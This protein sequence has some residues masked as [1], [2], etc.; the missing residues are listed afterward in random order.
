MTETARSR[1]VSRALALSTSREA[2]LAVAVLAVQIVAVLAYIGATGT[3]VLS[4]RETLYPVAWITLSVYFVA[5]VWR[6]GPAVRSS[7]AAVLA[8]L[9]YFLLLAVLA[10]FVWPG[11]QLLGHHASGAELT[12]FWRSPGWGPTVTYSSGVVQGAVV[13]FKL[14]AYSA[15]AY[16]I[17][18]A[19][20]A[21]SRG[22]LA[23]VVGMFSCV[24]CVL[25]VIGAVAGI[26][27]GSGAVASTVNGSYDLGT[28]VFAVTIVMLLV[29]IPTAHPLADQ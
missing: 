14:V 2:L 28:A 21:S 9:G 4:L 1:G 7:T 3:Q 24:G 12:V 13:P 17:A 20:A 18:A 26:F 6:Y 19:V 8:G 23:G 27:G 5:F 22:A 15:L 10:G 29:T 25:P 11:H 16:G